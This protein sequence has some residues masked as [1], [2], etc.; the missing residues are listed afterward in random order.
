MVFIGAALLV[1]AVRR[2]RHTV[3]APSLA[4]PP[5]PPQVEVPQTELS[6]TEL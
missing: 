5:A 4:G 6:Q 2:N 3:V 1:A